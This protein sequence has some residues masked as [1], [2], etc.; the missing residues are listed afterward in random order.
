MKP[1]EDNGKEISTIEWYDFIG[2]LGDI[3]PAL[4]LGGEEAT[5]TLLDI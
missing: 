3:I 1:E 5:R 2:N 4:H